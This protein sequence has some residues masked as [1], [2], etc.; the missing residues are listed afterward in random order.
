MASG[1]LEDVISSVLG[2]CLFYLSEIERFLS[3]LFRV[4][5]DLLGLCHRRCD[6]RLA[7]RSLYS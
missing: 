6:F 2:I 3:D 4:G 7:G 1:W 5:W